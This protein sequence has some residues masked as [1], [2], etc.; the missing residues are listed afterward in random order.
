M[1]RTTA[2][3]TSTG[4]VNADAAVDDPV[5]DRA[6]VAGPDPRGGEPRG[7]LAEG[8]TEAV[9]PDPLEVAADGGG[10]AVGVEHLE[11]QRGRAGVEHEHETRGHGGPF[12][13][14]A[15]PP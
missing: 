15:P 3:S 9:R 4:A 5:P 14:W 10:A 1:R 8:G 11:L 7:D 2:S 13:R 12:R 6:E